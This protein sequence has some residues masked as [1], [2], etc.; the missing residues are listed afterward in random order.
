MHGSCPV[1]PLSTQAESPQLL[2]SHCSSLLRLPVSA[3]GCIH[4]ADPKPPRTFSPCCP[5]RTALARQGAAWSWGKCSVH[6]GSYP[7]PTS[8]PLALSRFTPSLC[9]PKHPLPLLLLLSGYRSWQLRVRLRTGKLKS[10]PRGRILRCF[11]LIMV[12]SELAAFKYESSV[13]PRAREL[14]DKIK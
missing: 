7:V 10:Q 3:Q 11:P 8:H 6:A 4:P 5:C 1:F 14:S 2:R 12:F 9:L 13:L